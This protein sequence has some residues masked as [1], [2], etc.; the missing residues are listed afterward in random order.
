MW[1]VDYRHF[2]PGGEWLSSFPSLLVRELKTV[3][4]DC[5][6]KASNRLLSPPLHVARRP[7]YVK[8]IR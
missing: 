7:C 4:T 1:Q 2:E 6:E 3:K 8:R 5:S